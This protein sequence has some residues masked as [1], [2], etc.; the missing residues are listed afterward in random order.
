MP[1]Q[2]TYADPEPNGLATMLGGLIE[3]NL[4]AHPERDALLSKPAT[5]AITAPDAGVGVTIALAPGSVTLRNRVVGTPHLRIETASDNLIG[6]SAVPLRFGLPDAM[7]KEGRE[8]SRKLFK[9]E[10]KVHGLWLHPGK[11]ARLNKL[12]TVL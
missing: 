3:A 5:Y 12:L 11:L 8:V 10:L 4:L 2:V 1:A 9:G 6:L 7:T